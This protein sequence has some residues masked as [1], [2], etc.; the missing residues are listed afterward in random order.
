MKVTPIPMLVCFS[1]LSAVAARGQAPLPAGWPARLELGMADG[2]GFYQHVYGDGGR[3]W[4]HHLN[5]DGN[6][7]LLEHPVARLIID[8]SGRIHSAEP[9]I[10]KTLSGRATRVGLLRGVSTTLRSPP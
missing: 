2:P 6:L 7:Y 8:K 3:S 5:S 1:L 10:H 4:C 9:A